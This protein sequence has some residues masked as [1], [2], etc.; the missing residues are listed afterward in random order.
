MTQPKREKQRKQHLIL[1]ARVPGIQT[2]WNI[3]VFKARFS[4]SGSTMMLASHWRN[5]YMTGEKG[6]HQH[7]F[8][9]KSTTSF[10]NEDRNRKSEMS[11]KTDLHQDHIRDGS[12]SAP[13]I[14]PTLR[15]EWQQRC[16]K[17]PLLLLYFGKKKKSC[18][19]VEL[20][21]ICFC[22]A[23]TGTRKS[24]IHHSQ[25]AGKHKHGQTLNIQTHEGGN[26]PKLEARMKKTRTTKDQ[27]QQADAKEEILMAW[28]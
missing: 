19:K 8:N 16:G 14:V 22:P 7:K 26:R 10:R 6:F 3:L 13:L 28:L 24:H 5:A 25:R 18:G 20:E 12:Q 27:S 4:V 15:R 1:V 21:V 11:L 17:E 2:T 9:T 23:K